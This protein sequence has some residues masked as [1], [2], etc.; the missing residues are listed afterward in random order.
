MKLLVTGA[1]G[2]VGAAVVRAALAAGHDV[3]ATGR[4]PNP[5]RL[6]GSAASYYAVDLSDGPAIDAMIAHEQP[7][8]II[9]SA[10]EGVS[11]AAR[12][13]D[14]QL[15][16][17]TSTCRLIDAAIRGG[18]RKFVGI[19]SQAEY[20]R[21]DRL[22][23]EDDLP[24][25]T[26]IYGVAKLAACHFARQRAADAGLD[27]AWLRLFSPYGPS[28]NSNWLIPSL[29]AQMAAGLA[30]KM[31]MGKQRWDYLYIDDCADA[32]LA[33][34]VG[35]ATGVFNLCS[36]EA[37]L[38]RDVAETIRDLVAPRLDLIFGEIPYGPA[39]I[40][41]LQGDR[42]RLSAATGWAPRV[43][44]AVGVART[45]DAMVAA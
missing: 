15:T 29:I 20:G 19:G 21:F 3:V 2:F 6:R 30:P 40:M 45:V 24:E 16:N 23:S 12:D 25:P 14:I 43:A 39:Q 35:G 38:V 28:D 33:T 27:F 36:G 34:A 42:S 5:E 17:V 8:V 11:G 41:L 26:M 32:I 18:T 13:G 4:S 37:V 9:H 7:D 22:I 44:F 10:W 31:T 1:A